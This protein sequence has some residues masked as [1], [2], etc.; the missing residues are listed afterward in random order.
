MRIGELE[1]PGFEDLLRDARS[2]DAQLVAP[3]RVLIHGDFNTDNIIVNLSQRRVHLIDLHRSRPFDYLQDVSVFIVSNFR[4]KIFDP[5]P[6][7]RLDQ[8]S[9]EFFSFAKEF[10]DA[11]ADVS[12]DARLALGLAR[13]LLTSTRFDMDPDFSRSMVLRARYLI[14]RLLN[15]RRA[16]A[17]DATTPAA[18]IDWSGFRLDPATL[19]P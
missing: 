16:I 6:R 5:A 17:A 8:I 18:D 1:I 7:R 3:F 11:H 19:I 13:S 4:M 15:H 12:F 14:E 9:R 10:A 2:L